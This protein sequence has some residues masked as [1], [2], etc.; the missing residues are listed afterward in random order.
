MFGHLGQTDGWMRKTRP[1]IQVKVR[2]EEVFRAD[3]VKSC[4]RQAT[5][6]AKS[7]TLVRAST[8]QGWQVHAL[9][10]RTGGEGER[11]ERVPRASSAPHENNQPAFSSKL[12]YQLSP[13]PHTHLKA[14][15]NCACFSKLWSAEKILIPN[16]NSAAKT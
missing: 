11:E 16:P 13:S 12:A 14:V 10:R 8:K 7:T 4:T 15:M 3:A 1:G 2:P 9:W 6:T 5:A